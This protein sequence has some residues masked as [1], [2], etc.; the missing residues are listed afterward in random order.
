[1]NSSIM[2]RVRCIGLA[3]FFLFGGDVTSAGALYRVESFGVNPGG[4]VMYG[5]GPDDLEE[6]SPLIVLKK[7]EKKKN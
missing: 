7:K 1:M 5:Y 6:G 2:L 3:I 4:L